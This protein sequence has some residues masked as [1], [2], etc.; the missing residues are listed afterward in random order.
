M[1]QGPQVTDSRDWD[2]TEQL[3]D[4]HEVKLPKAKM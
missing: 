1:P 4:I 2:L 3:T